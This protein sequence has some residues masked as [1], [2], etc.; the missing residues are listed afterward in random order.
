[1]VVTTITQMLMMMTIFSEISYLPLNKYLN[2]NYRNKVKACTPICRIRE[3]EM[4]NQE[5]HRQE[6]IMDSNHKVTQELQA[7]QQ[8]HSYLKRGLSQPKNSK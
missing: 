6:R 5:T 8:T 7:H 2:L 3:I 4:D 1:M